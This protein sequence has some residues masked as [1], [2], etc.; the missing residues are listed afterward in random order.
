[1]YVRRDLAAAQINHVSRRLWAAGLLAALIKPQ[2]QVPACEPIALEGLEG[3]AFRLEETQLVAE[4]GHLRDVAGPVADVAAFQRHLQIGQ[5]RVDVIFDGRGRAVTVIGGG[6]WHARLKI[7]LHLQT[8]ETM[9]W[10]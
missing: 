7:H 9:R 5:G 8:S 2:L 1:M 6:L 3:E 10:A 4:L